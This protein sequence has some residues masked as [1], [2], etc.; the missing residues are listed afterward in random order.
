MVGEC[1]ARDPDFE[2]DFPREPLEQALDPLAS[3]LVASTKAKLRILAERSPPERC[4]LLLAQL[5]Y[6][7][8]IFQQRLSTH[9]VL[10]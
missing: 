9:H 2:F 4:A 6:E 3:A 10:H 8:I 1:R 5:A 7:R